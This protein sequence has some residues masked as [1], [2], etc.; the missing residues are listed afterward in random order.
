MFCKYCGARVDENALFCSTCGKRLIEEETN[1]TPIV[2]NEDGT[3]AETAENVTPSV[4]EKPKKKKAKIIIPIVIAAV[5]LILGALA[6]VYMLFIHEK[7]LMMPVNALVDEDGYAYLY[8]DNGKTVKIGSNVEWAYMTADHKKIIVRE[9]GR[10]YWTDAK[11]SEKHTV[12]EGLSKKTKEA[13]AEAISNSFVMIGLQEN[14]EQGD[15]VTKYYRYEFKTEKKV[16]LLDVTG[17]DHDVAYSN[18]YVTDDGD[19]HVAYANKGNIQLL[20]ADGEAAQ[21]IDEYVNGTKIDILGVSTDGKTVAW[22]EQK[23]DKYKLKVWTGGKSE[24]MLSASGKYLEG[25]DM[26]SFPSFVMNCAPD[27]S[28]VINGSTYTIFVKDQHATRLTFQNDVNPSQVLYGVNGTRMVLD[29]KFAKSEGYYV[30]VKESEKNE[31]GDTLYSVYFIRFSDGEKTRVLSHVIAFELSG[32]I[33]I[34]RDK[35]DILKWGSVDVKNGEIEGEE[36]ISGDIDRYFYAPGNDQYIYYLKES[37]NDDRKFHLYVYDVEAESTEKIVNDISEYCQVSEDGNHIYYVKDLVWDEKSYVTYGTVFVYHAKAEEHEKIATD[38]LPSSLDS[39]L[40]FGLFGCID[41]DSFFFV[42][43]N[44]LHEGTDG[45][46][47]LDIDLCYYN[48]KSVSTAV[49]NMKIKG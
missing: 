7:P 11:L 22:T 30:Q 21:T 6:A 33:A 23:D 32:D 4:E 10:I 12:L 37:V 42:K 49:K 36:T 8:Y 47:V 44:G 3:V 41:S 40:L 24:E 43:Y 16:L 19:I 27:G 5:V 35:S 34:Y 18:C 1:A 20:S 13:D 31:D 15:L 28:A 46:S 2:E 29:R 48:G 9:E 38:I 14:T 39:G 45:N 17:N 26:I 25:S